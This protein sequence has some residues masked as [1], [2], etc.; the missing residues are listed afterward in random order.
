LY[1]AHWAADGYPKRPE[2]MESVSFCHLLSWY[3]QECKGVREN[4]LLDDGS[5]YL[6][7]RTVKP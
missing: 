3:E 2:L 6:K 7:K 4:K 5:F 1:V